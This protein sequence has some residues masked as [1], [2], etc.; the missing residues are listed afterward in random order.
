MPMPGVVLDD[1]GTFQT[2]DS[3]P[4]GFPSFPDVPPGTDTP[5]VTPSDTFAPDTAKPPPADAGP[6]DAGPPPPVDAGPKP[7]HPLWD[8]DDVK[9]GALPGDFT[10]VLGTWASAAEPTAPS[11]P[12]VLRQTGAVG[13][14]EYPR[15]VAGGPTYH[16]LSVRVKC[17]MESGFTDQACGLMVRVQPMADDNYYVARANALEGNVRLY[18]V[19]SGDR[20]QIGSATASTDANTWHTLTITAMDTTLTVSW[21]GDEVISVTDTSYASG[22]V[23]LWT[24]ADSVTAFDDLEVFPK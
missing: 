3:T 22:R 16:N 24:K 12:N 1:L 11:K 15:V 14:S 23:G 2:V 18:R 8:F 20:Q 6:P 17:R 19:L 4:N 21:D 9:V 7:D 10:K 13:T 5:F